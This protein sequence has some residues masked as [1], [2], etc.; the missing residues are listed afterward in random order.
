MSYYASPTTINASKGFIEILN[1]VNTATNNW[2]SSLLLLGI[3]MV[4]A[5]G[6]YK[7]QNDFSGAMASAGFG[8]FVVGMLFWMGGFVTGWAF[9]ICVAVL[10]IGIMAVLM[11]K[12]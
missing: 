2:I 4:I 3:Y 6:Y 10:L 5:I 8:T 12:R 9:G 1:Y 11:D 7:A